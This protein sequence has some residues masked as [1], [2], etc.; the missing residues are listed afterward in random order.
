MLQPLSSP[1]QTV[2]RFFFHPLPSWDFYLSYLW[3]TIGVRPPIDLV[4]FALLYRLVVCSLL[5]TIYS[6]MGV[7]FTRLMKVEIISLPIYLL[8]EACQPYLAPYPITQF[9]Q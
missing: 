1:L 7:V 5:G 8:V 3:L 4:G 9:K 2:V 6:A